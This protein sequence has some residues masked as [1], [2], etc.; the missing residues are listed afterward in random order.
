[1]LFSLLKYYLEIGRWRRLDSREI[2]ARQIVRFNELFQYAKQKSKFYRTL[3]KK[4]NVYDLDIRTIQDIERLP[5]IDKSILREYPLS[6]ITTCNTEDSRRFNI[7]STSGSTGEPFKIAYSKAG[8]YTNQAR[9]YWSLRQYGYQ[10]WKKVLIVLRFKP[11]TLYQYERDLRWF[12][13]IQRLCPLFGRQKVSIYEPIESIIEILRQS[14]PYI[15]WSTPSM[16]Q[17]I[18]YKMEERGIRFSVPH[19]CV[20]GGTVFE[21]QAALFRRVFGKNLV[22]YYGTMEAPTLGFDINMEH[23][24]RLFPN[25]AMFEFMDHRV[26][27]GQQIA[28]LVLTNLINRTMPIIRY[29][30]RDIAYVDK[31]PDFGIKY[32]GRIIGRQDDIL[33]FPDGTY[34]G[35]THTYAMFRDFH[36][37]RQYRFVQYPDQT[38][39]LQLQVST[40]SDRESVRRLAMKRWQKRFPD[41]A[42]RIEFVNEFPLDTIAGKM[43][44]MV[45]LEA[46]DKDS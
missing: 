34:L 41:K 21:K 7:R 43:R 37:C 36:E 45:K 5:I 11:D 46:T 19:V 24:F 30:T 40:D 4:H 29:N 28:T 3:Y 14:E 13:F 18:A 8:D 31:D 15:L 42:L 9:H 22:N 10:P 25:S 17:I 26:E 39:A 32:L 16:L 1:M 2:R 20:L 44:S 12:R 35:V 27:D 23:R 6:E 38:I 33:Q